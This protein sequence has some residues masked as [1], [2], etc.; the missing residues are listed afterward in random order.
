M[1]M[2]TKLKLH[3]SRH[4]FKRGANKGDAPLGNRWRTYV[5]VIEVHNTM[6]VRMW[7]TDILKAYED[8]RVVLDTQGWYDRPTTKM[9]LNEALGFLAGNVRLGSSKIMGISQPYLRANGKT[10]RYYDGIK[11]DADGN[12]TS[13]LR[14]FERRQVNKT[15]SKELRDDMKA[16]GFPDAFKLLHSVSEQGNFSGYCATRTRE[17][18]TNDFHANHWPYMVARFTWE[19]IGGYN[20]DYRKRTV[21]EA[22]ACL[23]SHLRKD[24]YEVI[25]TDVT[26]L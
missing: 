18:V 15:E 19:R 9:R 13:P 23:T 1:N 21:A 11:L 24:C 10:V 3:L 17:V 16:C 25:A 5:R 6:R 2:Y 7:G 26:L 22:W 4:V 8:G 14:P 20:G 12:V